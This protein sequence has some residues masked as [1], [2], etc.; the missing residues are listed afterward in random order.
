MG[1]V[2]TKK[3]KSNFS[4]IPQ[5]THG[6]TSTQKKYWKVT[7]DYV[8]IRD[9]KSG[10]ISC[11]KQY[12]W[13]D[14]QWQA[15]HYKSWGSCRGYSK[16]DT[17]NIFGQCSSC[18]NGYDTNIIGARFKE[19]IIKRFGKERME[20]ID[21]LSSYPTEKMDDIVIQEKIKERILEMEGLDKKPPYWKEII[22]KFKK[23]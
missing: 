5:G 21:K 8:R 10:C 11:G 2:I 14:P 12:E 20:W 7:S 18:N 3:M 6:S 22:N 23:L 4:K 9:E 16:W 1:D 19:G 17:R 15:G 13:N